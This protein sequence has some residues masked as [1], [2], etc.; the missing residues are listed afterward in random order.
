METNIFQ[1]LLSVTKLSFQEVFQQNIGEGGDLI[2]Q[3]RLDLP[4]GFAYS[5]E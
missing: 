2:V 1:M 4:S 5:A 3:E